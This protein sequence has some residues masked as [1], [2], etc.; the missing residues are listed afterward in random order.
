RAHIDEPAGG[1]ARRRDRTR[2]RP[3]KA[4]AEQAAEGDQLPRPQD[5]SYGPASAVTGRRAYKMGSDGAAVDG[6]D[7]GAGAALAYAPQGERGDHEV[8][9]VPTHQTAGGSLGEEP[10]MGAESDRCLCAVET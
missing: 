10:G 7:Q 8:L 1:A 6:R 9:V 5:A 2:D 3:R 4:R